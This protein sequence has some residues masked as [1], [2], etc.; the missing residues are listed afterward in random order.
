[1]SSST[2]MY[3]MLY[4]DISMH[5]PVWVRSCAFLNL[6]GRSSVGVW[7]FSRTNSVDVQVWISSGPSRFRQI[8]MHAENHHIQV[9]V[10]ILQARQ[11]L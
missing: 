3:Y 8:C 11:P 9:C 6:H 10:S 2:N 7:D 1:M 5:K 4:S